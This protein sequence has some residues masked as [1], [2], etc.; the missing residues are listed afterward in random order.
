MTQR[1]RKAIIIGAGIAGPVSAIF[2]KRAGID[3]Q[4]FEAWPHSTGIGGGLQI[5]PNGMHVLAEIGLADEMIRRGSVA[6]AFEFYSQSGAKLGS[7]NRNMQQRFGQPAVNMCRATLLEAILA[8]ARRESVE[9]TFEK[10]LVLIEDRPDQPVALRRHGRGNAPGGRPGTADR[11]L[12]DQRLPAR[13]AARRARVGH[14]P[15]DGRRP[16]GG[17]R[18]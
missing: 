6:E 18:Q 8:T 11:L 14:R 15:E 10:R 7:I 2:L 16:L 4:V 5:A 13:R 1:S 3:A 17:Q 9:V 12:A